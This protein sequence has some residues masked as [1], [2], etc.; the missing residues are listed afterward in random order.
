MLKSELVR[1]VASKNRHLLHEEVEKIINAIF[2]EITVALERGDRVELRGFGVFSVTLR[3]AR[4]ARNPHTGT[5]VSVP[6]KAF[7]A[8][9]A[10]KEIRHRLNPSDDKK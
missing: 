4:T 8:F 6:G 7:S 9:K 10:G 1:I 2:E 5:Q 3:K